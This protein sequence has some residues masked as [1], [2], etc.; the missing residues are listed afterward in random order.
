MQLTYKQAR[1]F[2]RT[3]LFSALISNNVLRLH[4][5]A[6]RRLTRTLTPDVA[7]LTVWGKASNLLCCFS[8]VTHKRCIWTF[9]IGRNEATHRLININGQSRRSM[10]WSL[11]LKHLPIKC[12]WL[13]VIDGHGAGWGTECKCLD[14]FCLY[15][16]FSLY[17]SAKINKVSF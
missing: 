6:V 1:G 14:Y 16:P 15:S 3:C 4:H 5:N 11:S 10:R 12:R 9:Y 8:P 13:L 17:M 7:H 2:N